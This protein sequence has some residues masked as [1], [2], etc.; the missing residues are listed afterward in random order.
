MVVWGTLLAQGTAGSKIIFTCVADSRYWSGITLWEKAGG[1][2]FENA[3]FDFGGHGS[4]YSYA[5]LA[6]RNCSPIVKNCDFR[7]NE[8]SGIYVYGSAAQPIISQCVFDA[9]GCGIDFANF[10]SGC[11]TRNTI[12]HNA[13]DGIRTDSSN[14]T[15]EH[16]EFLSNTNG[17][18]INIGSSPL[19]PQVNYNHFSGNAQ[20]DILNPPTPIIFTVGNSFG[21]PCYHVDDK[22]PIGYETPTAYSYCYRNVYEPPAAYRLVTGVYLVYGGFLP[23]DPLF[24]FSYG[25]YLFS[26]FFGE[27]VNSC[28]GNYTATYQDLSIPG[29]GFAINLERSYNSQDT[30]HTGHLGYGWTHAYEQALCFCG[31]GSIVVLLA[32]GRRQTFTLN[33]DGTYTSPTGTF[34]KLVKNLDGTYSYIHKDQSRL[35]FDTFGNLTRLVDRYENTTT[36]AYNTDYLLTSVSAPGGSSLTFTYENDR[37]IKAQDSAGRFVEYGYDVNGNLTS[38]KDLNGKITTYTY[39][40]NHQLLTVNE[41]KQSANPFLTNHYV[42]GKIDY[43]YDASMSRTSF[44]YDTTASRTDLIDNNGSN[45]THYYDSLFRLT[46]QVN[47]VGGTKIFNYNSQGLPESVTDENS[48]TVRFFYD[49]NGNTTGTIDGA[50][51]ETKAGYDLATNNILWSEDANGARTTY[52]YDPTGKFLTSIANPVQS[53]QFTYYDDGLIHE[54]ISANATTT[55]EY[56][57]VGNLT[58]VTDSLNQPTSFGY[59]NAGRM[60]SATDANDHKVRFTYDNMGNMLAIKDTLS[61]VYPSERHQVDFTYD[62]NGNQASFTDANG[63]TSQFMYDDMDNLTGVVDA[64]DN[65]TTYTYNPNYMLSTTTDAKGNTT[66]YD[67]WPN[68]LLKSTKDAL[69]NLAQYFYDGVGNL[70][71]VIYPNGNETYCEYAAD[72]MPTRITYKNEPTSYVFE[73]NPTHTL[74]GVTD[75]QGRVFSYGYNEV[76]WLVNATD[77]VNPQ[78]ASGFNTSWTYDAAGRITGLKTDT[79][80]TK[81]YEYNLRG[82]LI[83]L[84]LPTDP[85]S[86]HTAFIYDNE[87]QRTEVATPDGTT[88]G[89]IYDEAGRIASVVNTTTS[90]N[91]Q[92]AYSYDA[93]GNIT[94][95]NTT[96]RYGYDALNR[97]TAWYDQIK[98]TTTTYSYDAAGNLTSAIEGTQTVKS[99]TYNSA[100]QITNAGFSYDVNGNLTSDDTHTYS[101]DGENRLK[102]IKRTADNHTI[103]TYEYDYLG[104]RIK[105]TEETQTT[106]FHYLGTTANV[107]AE[108]DASDTI[109]ARYSYDD[110]GQLIAMQKGGQTY[111][112]QFNAH[113]DVVSLTNSSGQV[114]NTYSYDPWGNIL[115]VNEQIANPYRY[116]GYR[117]D[118]NTDLYYLWHRY[119]S[120]EIGRF[121]C[122]D[123]Y[124]GNLRNPQSTNAYLFCLD[125]PIN[126]TDLDGRNPILIAALIGGGAGGLAYLASVGFISHG[127]WCKFKSSWNW[128]DFGTSVGFGAISGG[129]TGGFG[130]AMT[131]QRA[132]LTGGLSSTGQYLTSNYLQGKDITPAGYALSFALGSV[133]GRLGI[134]E[135]STGL[136]AGFRDTIL[137]TIQNVVEPPLERILTPYE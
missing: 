56:N 79:E 55:Y 50:G 51:H 91:Q 48:H 61:L 88:R 69:N 126:L 66:T 10:A 28:T 65:T 129:I 127:N 100:N 132:I 29:K 34:E 4:S 63:N 83:T 67:Y 137:G 31:D 76:G 121:L 124:P 2:R 87:R 90:G 108:S 81:T 27:P 62:D 3:E 103:A 5:A 78:M 131:V 35:N 20:Y 114:V 93:N 73:Y 135:A 86:S 134:G 92:F 19:P 77:T 40:T 52:A 24:N 82:D 7:Y 44:S 8:C 119:Y 130:T 118:V 96:T 46:K 101:Y 128:Y 42:N 57:A 98:D 89:Y 6:I 22:I 94:N 49:A 105:S 99:F 36:L 111:Y 95:V 64:L 106:Y 14:P 47:E 17:V 38:V 123:L 11:V 75:D 74:K 97:L 32:D 25:N 58:K 26:G 30:T 23:G 120:P 102:E 37:I 117:Y 33:T 85:T 125:N 71:K 110:R 70:T 116:A 80:D 13:D 115:S 53:M 84:F 133:G 39:D 9:N 18:R 12:S 1:S 107:I 72:N 112:Y 16:N 54:L 136:V 109:A 104:R 59:D 113:G 45:L 21:N 43:Q 122:R 41:P 68:N 15:V 60:T